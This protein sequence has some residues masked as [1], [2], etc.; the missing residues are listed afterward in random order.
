M[1]R[2][3]PPPVFSLFKPFMTRLFF[4][5]ELSLAVAAF[6]A[7]AVAGAVAWYYRRET[8]VLPP[9]HSWL[10]P[11]LRA[12]AIFV[13]LMM[14]AEPVVQQ[15]RELGTIG[16]VDVFVDASGSMLATDPATEPQATP[17]AA[18]ST[19]SQSDAA[20]TVA[21]ATSQRTSETRLQRASALLLGRSGQP[22]WLQSVEQTHH[23][24][25][26]L[27]VDD[28]A[29]LIW[30]SRSDQPIPNS[31]RLEPGNV[32]SGRTE[33]ATPANLGDAEA[34]DES[35]PQSIG[36]RTNLSDPVAER[37]LN[38]S[39]AGAAVGSADDSGAG[40]EPAAAAGSSGGKSRRAVLLL[41]DG[42]HN[43]GQSPQAVA[44]RLGD[45]S[46][47][48]FAIG[49]GSQVEP[50]DVAVLGI[51]VPPIVASSGR[52]SGEVTIKD[53]AG[54]DA[55]GQGQRVRVR[56]MMGDQT[57]WQQ[58]LTSENRPIRRVPFDFAIQPL[59]EKVQT[60]DSGGIQRTRLTLP[61]TVAI[62]PIDGQYDASNNRLDFR[63]AANLRKRRLLIVDSR[64][65]WETRYI[66]NL[67][68][69]DPTWQVDSVFAWPRVSGGQIRRHLTEGTFPADAQTMASYDAVIWGDC[70][71]E[72]F[73]EEELKRLRDFANQ[74]G[75]VVFI[76]G[77]RDGL[78]RLAR[79]P[80][81]A[82]L[83]VRIGDDPLVMGIRS[84]RPTVVGSGQSALRLASA[85]SAQ[86]VQSPAVSDNDS[87]TADQ[88]TWAQL[89]PPTTVRN[90]DVLPGSEVW[91]EADTGNSTPAVPV[92]VTRLFGG[93]QV[94]YMATDQTWR[95]RYRVA[96]RYHTRFWNQLLEAIMQPPYEVRDQYIA[97]ATGSPQYTAGQSAT[98]RARLRDASGRPVGDAIVEAVLKD[99]AGDAQT[100][101]LRSVDSDRG[102]YEAQSPPLVAGQYDVSIRSAGYGSSQAVRTSLLVVPPPD[103][104]AVRLALDDNLL[105][106][107]TTLSGGLYADE[108]NADAVWRAIKPLSDGTIETRRFALTQSYLWFI[109]V[110]GLL[111]TEWW[112][113]KK[114]GLV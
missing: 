66:R 80:A 26:H 111:T 71:P 14:L 76:D 75:A 20:V 54:T 87:T 46:V 30:D 5:G 106:S 95:W 41:T 2:R 9:P 57:V 112:L 98:I 74:G 82:L 79:S 34:A 39:S 47:P 97:I 102:V 84:L 15:K 23:V 55:S 69:R 40:N 27:L 22:G 58:S 67:F 29:K 4:Q 85:N 114:A 70:G 83:P 100:V 1:T 89:P 31:L 10:L 56:I 16:R 11:I 61:L 72:A 49:L 62:D 90:A 8:R 101:L 18:D 37:V 59:A 19:A 21:D 88:A 42:Q 77:D 24:F 113:R 108:S 44:Q 65:R 94:V 78:R 43:S 96:D 12:A 64:S 68:D 17:P 25:L 35:L 86:A 63:I 81:A 93:G 51:N 13:A 53:L 50:R 92:L 103:R 28:D 33:N 7:A 99:S 38:T 105:R 36:T 104:E 107:M 3:L 32:A 52:A 109:A 91:L 73:T 60:Q 110:L 6:L 48:L 45:S